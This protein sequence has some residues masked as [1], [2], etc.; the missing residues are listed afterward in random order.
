MHRSDARGD[1]L[2]R[3]VALLARVTIMQDRRDRRNGLLT[4][5]GG[6][7][8]LALLGWTTALRAAPP[9]EQ[10]RQA[11]CDPDRDP[12]RRE[13][14]LRQCLPSLVNLDDL[15]AALALREWGDT[16][17]DEQ[18]AVVDRAVR[19]ILVLRFEQ[20]A[21]Q[22]LWQGDRA[23]RRAV[24]DLLADM[25]ITVR[26]AQGTSGLARELA[27][28]LAR[29]VEQG[30]PELRTPAARAL[31]FI[32]ADA[33]VAGP[34][35]RR[36][37][38][39]GNDAERKAAAW[40]IDHWL[41][42]VSQLALRRPNLGNATATEADWARVGCTLLPLIGHGLRDSQPEVRRQCAAG[43]SQVASTLDE[44]LPEPGPTGESQIRSREEV[45]TSL[46]PVV[47]A[48]K[49]QMPVLTLALAD[50]D[51]EVRVRARQALHDLAGAQARWL[52]LAKRN[53]GSAESPGASGLQSVAYHP[54]KPA[55][56]AP[57]AQGSEGTL[58]A[59]LVGVDDRNV[60]VRRATLEALEALGP[61]AALAM[62]SLL[63]AL[64]DPDPFVRWTAART[65]G[66][67]SPARADVAV[68]ALARLLQDVDFDLRLAALAA[69]ERYGPAAASIVPRLI[70]SLGA[71]DAEER[72]AVVRVLG[73]VGPEAKTAVV[74]I[75][76]RLRDQDERVRRAAAQVLGLLGSNAVGARE[77]LLRALDDPDPDVRQAVAEALVRIK[78]Y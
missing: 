40:A 36:L 16:D 32:N 20:A 41:H 65:L 22:F 3:A 2:G 77:A 51:S 30:P 4:R 67:V 11:L 50:V 21:R 31:G 75:A 26:A 62:P 23:V 37:L 70:D 9:V 17:A 18:R 15:R 52:C 57:L 44:L 39:T 5:L 56:S 49:E 42:L 27:P 72:V 53:P 1:G 68:P 6:M 13:S 54:D 78:C 60:T 38:E 19:R 45:A 24:I 59:L 47:G 48:L 76:A 28:D 64:G 46:R 58:Q 10:L 35:L 69:L 14:R 73:S 61:A 71:A 63:K 25:G 8:L 7:A 12:V 34:A 43:I 74:P 33:D 55:A 66:K 29:L